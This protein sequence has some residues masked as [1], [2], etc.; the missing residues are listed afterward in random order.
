MNS[1]PLGEKLHV[2]GVV[3]RARKTERTGVF[4]PRAPTS[5]ARPVKP[6][7]TQQS[8]ACLCRVAPLHCHPVSDGCLHNFARAPPPP[9]SPPEPRARSQRGGSSQQGTAKEEGQK[10]NMR[11][12]EVVA[13]STPPPEQRAKRRR[14]VGSPR[15]F[16]T[17]LAAKETQSN[18][19][20]PCLPLLPQ[21]GQSQLYIYESLPFLRRPTNQKPTRANKAKTEAH[22]G[23][24]TQARIEFGNRSTP[25]IIHQRVCKAQFRPLV[26]LPWTSASPADI[27]SGAG[28]FT[29]R[30]SWRRGA[31]T[32][33]RHHQDADEPANKAS[34]RDGEK[35]RSPPRRR[36]HGDSQPPALL[37]RFAP[38]FDCFETIVS[39]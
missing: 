35:P 39:H 38:E 24:P 30:L 2:S 22:P 26:D 7:H 36:H 34:Q 9:P 29:T 20:P 18:P 28:A 21:A 5:P 31:G 33:G 17:H 14:P 15:I 37:P 10:K 6:V 3:G 19:N 27:A 12:L 32:S 25:A 8:P 16:L 23:I 11:E 4:R 1:A 13:T